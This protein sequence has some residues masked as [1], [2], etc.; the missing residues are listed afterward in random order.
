MYH[1]MIPLVAR[2]SI[3]LLAVGGCSRSV[4]RRPLEGAA[5]TLQGERE[6]DRAGLAVA[7][8]EDLD[9]D[10]ISDILVGAPYADNAAQAGGAVYVV[11]GAT[12]GELDLGTAGA[13]LLSDD[14]EASAGHSVAMAGDVD[15]D[16]Y[17]DALIGAFGLPENGAW[18]GGAYLVRGP[19]AGE[20][21]LD[22][23]D[24][25]LLGGSGYDTAGF[26]VAGPLDFDGDGLDD[27]LVSAPLAD[28]AG[29]RS[30]EAYLFHGPVRG[31]VDL[32]NADVLLLGEARG[33][34]A[35][36][37]IAAAD[38]DGD[39]RD[40][41][42]VGGWQALVDRHRPGVVYVIRG[43]ASGE[44]RLADADTRLVGADDGERAGVALAGV[45]DVDGDGRDDLLVG[46]AGGSRDPGH[47]YL[48][49]AIADGELN[50]SDA[51]AKLVGEMVGDSVGAALAG[52]GDVDGDGV[53]DLLLGG[54]GWGDDDRDAGAAY[55]VLAGG[56]LA[57]LRGEVSLGGADAMWGGAAAGDEVGVAVSG[58]G[59]L[60][61][62][63]LN[64]L[65]VGA[66]LADAP[67]KNA[68]A[69]Y[70]LLEIP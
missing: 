37:A 10:G 67:E 21:L 55:L 2:P 18:S 25:V 57:P 15:G 49:T 41:I 33:D 8:G 13:I 40:D 61:G 12:R 64:D 17:G 23:A 50:L 26:A 60:N 54:P 56:S 47:A 22:G 20:L 39:G 29:N 9:G 53:D 43:P 28:R 3:A 31:T 34:E 36:H 63:G 19:I 65:V 30:G 52:P 58:A 59:D 38:V 62:V 51:T 70:L 69:A 45:G 11:S 35:A 4:E 68:G 42:I 32:A 5:A 48:V 1:R 46:T 7:G 6:E 66:W 44:V 24:A 27:V 14:E 16:G